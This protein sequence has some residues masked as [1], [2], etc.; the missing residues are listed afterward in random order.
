MPPDQS[1]D[2]RPQ[3]NHHIDDNSHNLRHR[4]VSMQPIIPLADIGAE[5]HWRYSLPVVA[6]RPSATSVQWIVGLAR[7]ERSYLT[8]VPASDPILQFRQ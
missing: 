8:L 6:S 2:D 1:L 3:L 4:P 7:Q 5:H